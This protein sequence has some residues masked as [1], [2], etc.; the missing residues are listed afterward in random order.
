ML[1]LKIKG[2]EKVGKGFPG[3]VREFMVCWLGKVRLGKFRLGNY[4][5]ILRAI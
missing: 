4:M 5:L 3:R 2:F 1:T